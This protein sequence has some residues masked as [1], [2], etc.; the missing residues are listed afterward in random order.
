M[1]ASP[2]FSCVRKG[3]GDKDAQSHAADLDDDGIVFDLG[4]FTA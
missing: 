4:N 2:A 1:S 3:A